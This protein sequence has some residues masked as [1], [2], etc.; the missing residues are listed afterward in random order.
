MI[1][2]FWKVQSVNAKN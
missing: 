2:L 1:A